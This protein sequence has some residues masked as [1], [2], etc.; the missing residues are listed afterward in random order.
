MQAYNQKSFSGGM[1]QQSDS[2]RLGETE[3]PLLINGRNRF[4]VISPIKKPRLVTAGLPA[5]GIAQGIASAGSYAIVFIG[6]VAYYKDYSV[7]NSVFQPL[8][9]FPPL[10]PSV[11][12]VYTA[13]VEGSTINYKRVPVTGAVNGSITLTSRIQSL[14]RAMV[15]QDGVSRP[16]V[17]FP[18]GTSRD[19][20]TYAQWDD[21]GNREYVPVGT[22]M[23]FADGILYIVAGDYLLRSITGRPLDFMVNIRSDGSKEPLESDGSAYTVAHRVDYDDITALFKLSTDDGGLLSCSTKASTKVIPYFD[24]TIFAEPTFINQFLFATGANNHVSCVEG[25]GDTYVIDAVGIRSFNSILNTKNEGENTPFHQRVSKIFKNIVQDVTCCI[26]FDDYIFFAVKTVYGYGVAVFDTITNAWTGVDLYDGV[27]AIKQ[28]CEVKTGT[29]KKLLFITVD[30]KVY[31]AF[32]D[33]TYE[34]T[35]LYIGDWCSND[36]RIEQKPFNLHVVLR[37]AVTAGTFRASIF[38]DNKLEKTLSESVAANTDAN[39]YPLVIPFGSG[40]HDTIRNLT[41]DFARA[42]RGWKLGYLLEWDFQCDLTH[43]SATTSQE[44]DIQSTEMAAKRFTSSKS[45]LNSI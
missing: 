18:D 11:Y 29:A 43:V 19:A 30:N 38:V 23:C 26:N 10:D 15:V 12:W 36:P 28:F 22:V 32:S 4:D 45:I 44:E 21:A 27:G 14:P 31:E 40:N 6:G 7:D 34:T 42:K 41:F 33:D 13:L 17:I 25:L 5:S 37:D 35:K 8:P 3:Y 9:N 16:K 24:Q 2:T 1:N 39:D 20:Q